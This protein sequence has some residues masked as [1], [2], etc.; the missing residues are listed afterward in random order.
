MPT[1]I[2]EQRPAEAIRPI[3]FQY[4]QIRPRAKYV[5]G[6]AVVSSP[7][8][9]GKFIVRVS[10]WLHNLEGR[11]A[12]LRIPLLD[13]EPMTGDIEELI[14]QSNGLPF[15]ALQN[16]LE[17]ASAKKPVRPPNSGQLGRIIEIQPADPLEPNKLYR[18]SFKV[19][20]PSEGE[21]TRALVGKGLRDWYI[22]SG[23]QVDYV[24]AKVTPS[25]GDA[26]LFLY[27]SGRV[28]QNSRMCSRAGGTVEDWVEGWFETG[29]KNW[30]LEV[31]G[32]TAASYSL[33][34]SWVL[35]AD[36][37]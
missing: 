36:D 14:R 29:W 12:G 9:R 24:S 22:P 8:G 20:T 16:Q 23:G 34:G 2:G 10:D 21:G 30:I 17:E 35:K 15:N 13:L 32:W 7:S 19:E 11:N 4:E 1:I 33:T 37:R 31:Y 26:D 25:G 27:L 6:S 5:M 3:K 28:T 18:L